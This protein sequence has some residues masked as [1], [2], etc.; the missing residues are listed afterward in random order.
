[1]AKN[2]FPKIVL[3]FSISLNHGSLTFLIFAET[4]IIC[5][6]G[7][8]RY[9][10]GSPLMFCPNTLARPRDNCDPINVVKTLQTTNNTTSS[11]RRTWEDAVHR[12]PCTSDGST[13]E[14]GASPRDLGYEKNSPRK[15]EKKKCPRAVRPKADQEREEERENKEERR[16]KEGSGNTRRI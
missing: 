11:A 12:G 8:D 13:L 6:C 10:R 15:K 9:H 2:L 1:M 16:N 5:A 4:F 14:V 7:P 3:L